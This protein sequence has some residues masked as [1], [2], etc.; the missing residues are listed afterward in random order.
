MPYEKTDFLVAF[1]LIVVMAV[2]NWVIINLQQKIVSVEEEK[3]QLYK[4]YNHVLERNYEINAHYLM[5]KVRAKQYYKLL[6]TSSKQLGEILDPILESINKYDAQL[7]SHRQQR[8][9]KELNLITPIKP[10]V[11]LQ[12]LLTRITILQDSLAKRRN[13]GI[14]KEFVE[15]LNEKTTKLLSTIMVPDN[16]LPVRMNTELEMAQLKNKLLTVG[17]Q[18][19]SFLLSRIG[20]SCSGIEWMSKIESSTTAIELGE[21][22]DT[23]IDVMEYRH[24]TRKIIE[25]KVNGIPLKV[26]HGRIQFSEKP[27]KRGRYHYDVEIN[28][29]DAIFDRIFVQKKRFTYVVQ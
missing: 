19:R 23:E 16:R 10:Q 4:D 3:L 12:K 11:N 2:S 9:Y 25:A 5:K 21:T 22:F 6:W 17:C 15:E 13:L 14:R 7:I 28:T 18:H 27:V 26:K 29:K 24:S 1:L 20:G 8:G